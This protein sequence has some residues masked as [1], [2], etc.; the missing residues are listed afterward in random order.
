MP[1][2]LADSIAHAS[3]ALAEKQD[4][5]ETFDV[6]ERL[7]KP[8]RLLAQQIEVEALQADRPAA[9]QEFADKA[10]SASTY[11]ASSCARFSKEL[12]EGEEGQAEV[13]ELREGIEKVGMPEE[14]EKQA[15]K[16]LKRS[17]ARPR[18]RSIP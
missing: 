10:A 12:G 8:L 17:S 16:E 13:A 6:Q 11:C 14:A 1:A 3:T 7:D 4:L 15:L 5:L 18:R 2:Q 9:A